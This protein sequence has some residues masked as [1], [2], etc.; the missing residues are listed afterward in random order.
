MLINLKGLTPETLPSGNTR[1]RVRAK[2]NP[3][4]KTVIHLDPSHPN[5][6]EHYNL[7]RLGLALPQIDKV[8]ENQSLEG[9][10]G[11]LCDQYYAYM[12]KRVFAG[13]GSM[14]TLKKKKNQFKFLKGLYGDFPMQMPSSVVRSIHDE[15]AGTPSAADDILETIKTLYTWSSE[16]KLTTLNPA[17]GVKRYNI[18][19]GG[20]VSWLLDDVKKYVR[21]Y[22]IGTVEY[23]AISLLLF[24]A[25]RIGDARVLGRKHEVKKNGRIWL[26]WT[27]GKKGSIPLEIPMAPQLIEATRALTELGP[28]YLMTTQGKMFSSGDS[29]SAWFVKTCRNAGIRNRSAHGLRKAAGA[30]LAE[31]G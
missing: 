4:K 3:N 17:L 23:C 22:K 19:K 20:A 16:R 1:Y 27:P 8:G 11:W 13:I 31:M 26:S 25:C 24:S 6:M 9:S 12:E 21:Y 15:K 30:I 18:N 28:A 5:F 10:F 14:T 29:M 7:A 2:G